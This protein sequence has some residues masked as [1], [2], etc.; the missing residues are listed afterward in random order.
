MKGHFDDVIEY[1][2]SLMTLFELHGPH[3]LAGPVGAAEAALSQP[4]SAELEPKVVGADCDACEDASFV[5]PNENCSKRAPI[6]NADKHGD[7]IRS[8]AVDNGQPAQAGARER[9]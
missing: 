7:G 4:V 5:R 3:E 9:R 6:V 1:S 8:C 2:V